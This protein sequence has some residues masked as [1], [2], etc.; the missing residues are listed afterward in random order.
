MKDDRLDKFFQKRLE[1]HEV[2]PPPGLFDDIQRKRKKSSRGFKPQWIAAAIAALVTLTLPFYFASDD[3]P[4]M[5]YTPRTIFPVIQEDEPHTPYPV[6]DVKVASSTKQAPQKQIQQ[7]SVQVQNSKPDYSK[8]L[9]ND[10]AY[11][12][13]MAKQSKREGAVLAFEADLKL[14]EEE[15]L[16]RYLT[17]LEIEVIAEGLNLKS[18][19]MALEESKN[20]IG[21]LV[22]KFF[23]PDYYI[24][25]ESVQLPSIPLPGIGEKKEK[26]QTNTDSPEKD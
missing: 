7:K 21:P 9:A 8:D 24:T 18:E 12:D 11:I 25:V 20:S 22:R 3:E 13:Q 4:E 19:N 10:L 1:N 6:P 15:L 2:E 23:H 17:S 16:D 14:Y 5:V 26:Q